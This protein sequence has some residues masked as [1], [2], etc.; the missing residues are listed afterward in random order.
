MISHIG[1]YYTGRDR[2]DA[3]DPTQGDR[4]VAKCMASSKTGTNDHYFESTAAGLTAV[5]QHIATQISF[6]LIK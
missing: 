6:R 4:D 5:F 1:G 3:S 2:S